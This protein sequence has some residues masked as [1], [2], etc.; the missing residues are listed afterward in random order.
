MKPTEATQAEEAGPRWLG[1]ALA[2]SAF[3]IW[4]FSPIFYKALDHVPPLEVLSHRTIWTLI[5]I[6]G[7]AL[8]TGRRKRLTD[9]LR[10]RRTMAA[11]ALAAILIAV[12]WFTFIFAVQVG[13]ATESSLGYYVFPL[14]SVALGVLVLK[15][16]LTR[17]QAVAVA[18]AALAVLLLTLGL[19]AA[20]WI[21]LILSSTMAVYGLLK[22]TISVGPVSTV[23]IEA[24]LLTPLAATWLYGAHVQ[25]WVGLIDR[26]GGWFGA[27]WADTALLAAS[28]LL[29]GGPLL[30]FAEAAHRLR[31]STL[32][33][34][35][36]LNPTLQFFCAVVIF[37]EAFTLWHGVAFV[38]IWA[39]I[40]IY[41]AA[42]S[43]A[44]RSARKTSMTSS[45]DS[46]IVK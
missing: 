15:E 22:K 11:L 43:A 5:F 34:L 4:G 31:Y 38:M 2:L 45:T 25:G 28:G 12:N 21:A 44:E 26:P 20:P 8:L 32:G 9:A 30:L 18:L 19:G 37:G 16:S 40:A 23:T 6:G 29:T 46:Q 7:Y 17:A 36:Y 33:L 27:N 3:V 1:V 41:S 35:Q 10:S 39:A 13:K 24:L 14:M 42:A